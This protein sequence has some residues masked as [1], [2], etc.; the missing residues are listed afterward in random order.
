MVNNSSAPEF[1]ATIANPEALIIQ[2]GDPRFQE[3]FK[4]FVE[5]DK[6]QGMLGFKPGSYVPLVIPGG[7]SHL[8][9]I[10]AFPKNFKVTKEQIEFFLDHFQTIKLIVLINHEDCAGY[11]ELQKKIGA[12]IFLRVV[13]NITERQKIDLLKVAHFL[14]N[15]YKIKAH[16][17]MYYAKF[18]NPE[19]TKISFEEVLLK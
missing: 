17:K 5:G 8:T 4:L 14:A 1:P 15:L 12:S 13:K 19:H 6:A 7:I 3:A 2:C 18:A 16:F 9:E 10:Y 11:Q